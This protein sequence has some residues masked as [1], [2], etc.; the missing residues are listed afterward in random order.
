MMQD[1]AHTLTM[2][3][4]MRASCEQVFAALLDEAAQRVWRC[5]QGYTV[6]QVVSD[7]RAGGAWRLQM[8]SP[9][10]ARLAM[11]GQYLEVQPPNRLVFSWVWE[12]GPLPGVET[13]VAV[14]LQ[15][16]DGGT[17]LQMR[18]SGFPAEAV[19]D[20]HAERWHSIFDQLDGYLCHPQA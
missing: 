9:N 16:Q 19:R 10:G 2:S 13:L 3:R 7:S 1:F 12:A 8:L 6:T 4:F 17:L 14:D 11:G 18:H 15:P 5:P 20:S